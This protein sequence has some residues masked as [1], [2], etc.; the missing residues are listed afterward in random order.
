MDLAMQFISNDQIIRNNTLQDLKYF[1][2]LSL[3]TQARKGE[4][5]VSMMHVIKNLLI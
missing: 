1:N 3:A 2:S 4:Q 5:L